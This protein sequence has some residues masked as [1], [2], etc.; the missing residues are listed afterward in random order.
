MLSSKIMELMLIDI[1]QSYCMKQRQFIKKSGKKKTLMVIM[2]K[3]G[4]L[5]RV[6]V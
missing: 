1:Y 2:D 3:L 5:L 4:I 6:I